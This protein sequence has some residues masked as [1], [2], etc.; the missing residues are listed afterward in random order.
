MRIQHIK[1]ITVLTILLA[2]TLSVVSYFGAFVPGTYESDA[3]SMA[4]Q[5]MGQDMVDLFLVV[6]LLLITIFFVNK[7]SRVALMIFSGTVFYILYSFVIY[8]FGVHFNRLFLLYCATFGLSFYIF[9][10]IIYELART[11]IQ[12]WFNDNVPVRS[13]GFYFIV[14]ASMFYMLWLKDV[15]PAIWSNSVPASVRDYNLLVNP[16]YMCWICP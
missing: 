5:G 3:A 4:A 6:P 13:I 1:S 15:L 12:D 10:L 8:S 14:I 7:N 9:V 11:E 2:L 16:A